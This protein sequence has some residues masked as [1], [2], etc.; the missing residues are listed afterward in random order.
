MGS[1]AGCENGSPEDVIRCVCEREG[2]GPENAV[3]IP[4]PSPHRDERPRLWNEIP[5]LIDQYPKL[6]ETHRFRVRH[7]ANV[8]DL[9]LCLT[10]PLEGIRCHTGAE[11]QPG[12][13]GFFASTG[14]NQVKCMDATGLPDALDPPD[15]LLEPNRRPWQLE[16][17]HQPASSLQ[18]ESLAGRI[19]CKQQ[20][21]GAVREGA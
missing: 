9:W 7:P 8:L 11:Q 6:F 2:E 12:Y 4:P 19:G 3:T 21:R 20:P 1:G 17:H 13:V 5:A 15:S 10:K 16:V 18:V 14:C